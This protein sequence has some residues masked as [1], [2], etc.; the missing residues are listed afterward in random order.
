VD[1]CNIYLVV[2]A[3]EC[4]LLGVALPFGLEK[5]V[6]DRI[7]CR[8]VAAKTDTRARRGMAQE[9]EIQGKGNSQHL[10]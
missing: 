5:G 9:N 8:T 6:E 3:L 10:H 2:K 7:A 1:S 4:Q